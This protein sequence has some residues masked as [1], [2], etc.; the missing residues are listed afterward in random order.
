MNFLD[1][2][3]LMK[4]ATLIFLIIFVLFSSAMA[5]TA[6]DVINFKLGTVLTGDHA[7]NLGSYRFAE[8]VEEKTD[9]KVKITVYPNGQL[10]SGEREL[11]EGEQIGVVDLAVTATGP[12]SGFS[13]L[14]MTVDLPYL[15]RD[16]EHVDKVLDGPTGRK[17]LDALENAGIKGLAFWENGFRNFTNNV[18]PI[19][20]PEDLKSLKIRVMENPVH[21][22]IIRSLGA[23][24]TPMAWGEVYTSLQTGVIDGQENPVAIIWTQ[25][26]YEVQKYMCIDR[27]VYS[28]SPLTMSLAKFNSLSDE[29]KKIFIDCAIEA[30]KYERSIIR[31]SESK[32]IESIK[33]TGVEVTYPDNAPFLE[34][35]KSVYDKY[36]EEYPEW[37]P[38]VEEILSTY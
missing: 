13:S 37:E 12:L 7:Y 34:A 9:G 35:T 17:I 25:K 19:N 36:F 30:G 18:R 14:M 4:L 33:E 5:E 28:P 8:L 2:R 1:R 15:F 23:L 6:E 38:I 16:N 29:H 22:D 32:D 26:V 21:M 24:A 20:S 10:G 27:H 11:I 31:D 3:C